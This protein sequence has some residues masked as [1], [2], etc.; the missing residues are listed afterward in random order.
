MVDL[1]IDLLGNLLYMEFF[2]LIGF[3]LSFVAYF[4]FTLLIFAA[5]NKSL[6]AQWTIVSAL[7]TA[8][9]SGMSFIQVELGISLQW[10]MIADGVKIACWSVMVLICNTELT[11]IRRLLSNFHIR[12]Y[13]SIWSILM[14]VCWLASYLLDYSYEYLFL[15]FI[16]LNLWSLVLI[17]QLYRSADDHIRWAI[18]P[19][20]IALA[21]VSIFDFV[22]YAQATMIGG[23]DFDFWYS[24]GYVALVIV[25][26]LLISTRR[27]KNG[28][29]RIF[30]SRQ[31]VFYSS[32]LMMAGIYLLVM[33]FAGY[34]INYIG[35]EW[36]SLVSIA[37]LML[38]GIVLVSLLI[39][40]S[41]R[42][43]LKVFIAK[44]F[45]AN[46]YEYRD[47]WL[48]LIEKIETTSAESYYQMA[49]GIMMAKL[50][51][52]GGSI[53][54]KRTDLDFDVKYAQG[55]E[56]SEAFDLQLTFF[57][58]FCHEKGWIIDVD[59]YEL[60]PKMYPEL[61]IDIDLCRSFNVRII[62]PIFIGKAFYGLF[63]MGNAPAMKQLNWEDRDLIFAV[64][65][66]LGNF[67]SL[68]EANDELAESKQFDAF[69]RMSAF[70]VHDLKNVQAQLA[71][72][73]TNAERHRDNPEFVDDVFET[74]ESATERL[75]KVLSQL[76]N[77]RVSQSKD[78]DVDMVKLI[79]KVVA[80]RNVDKPEVKIES[81]S[82]CSL[83][84]NEEKLH[85]VLNHLIQNAQEA[86]SDLGWVKVNVMSATD[87]ITITI[88]DNGCGMSSQFIEKRLFKP[89]DTTKGNA[90][91]GIGVFEA[92][93]FIESIAGN[94]KVSS[95]TDQGTTFN[96]RL[97]IKAAFVK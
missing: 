58:E 18:W 72:I 44:N 42:K 7:S 78:K 85:S 82:S 97:P 67:I 47:E 26:L 24:R 12:Q 84:I 64:S 83:A 86:T 27:I 15:L 32:I 70:L 39:T 2:G 73:T 77:K 37:F 20:V 55:L 10:V 22:L 45:F 43:K 74:V 50:N 11:S 65:K 8:L 13:V 52:N 30:V 87:A 71:L 1:F 69:N 89:F 95:I 35:G 91:M 49:T 90:G 46:R 62:V 34:I 17:E 40:E 80:Q 88:E 79:E 29:V 41:L 68:H 48:N 56:L 19:L 38:S 54:K 3:A 94:I 9:A 51:T 36:G 6:L 25:P 53:I 23:I 16:V 63:V 4:V 96:I 76:R 21:S 93:Q 92:K 81:I 57:S 75:S 59:E 60:T 14:T 66:Q 31:V 28:S 33:A 5:R 61:T